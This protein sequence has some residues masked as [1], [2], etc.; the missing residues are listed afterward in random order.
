MPGGTS[1][2][3]LDR[4][5]S[6]L[7]HPARRE[8]LDRLIGGA[9]SVTDLAAPF[10]MSLPA[11]SLHIHTLEKAGL[12]AQGRDGQLRPCRLDAAP[13]RELS[14]WLERYRVFWEQSL[15]RLDAYAQ[16]LTDDGTDGTRSDD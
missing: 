16:T 4:T 2:Q 8:I 7:A 11:V 1:A 10:D 15:D 12:V 13:L 9:R 3:Q 14:V 6:A 5:L